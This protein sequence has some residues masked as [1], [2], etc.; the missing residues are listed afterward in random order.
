MLNIACRRVRDRDRI[1]HRSRD[2]PRSTRPRAAQFT[3]V[4][5]H[6]IRSSMLSV[7]GGGRLDVFRDAQRPSGPLR[8]EDRQC[9]ARERED[10]LGVHAQ[11]ESRR[12]SDHRPHHG[13]DRSRHERGVASIKMPTDVDGGGPRRK[14]S[15]SAGAYPRD[16]DR[17]SA[18]PSGG[19][20]APTRDERVRTSTRS[21]IMACRTRLFAGAL[22]VG[23]AGI[24]AIG[25]A[26][27]VSGTAPLI[28][29]AVAAARQ[30]LA[31]E[32]LSDLSAP[33]APASV[34]RNWR[35]APEWRPPG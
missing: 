7:I 8:R 1:R 22:D 6:G 14:S 3:G 12:P 16:T 28:P 20:C 5:P 35:L 23:R 30:Q 4:G 21:R 19:R 13:N 25:V 15:T 26:W 10:A 2:A 27:L 32:Q 33:F 11:Q 9:N 24:R 34:S 29:S 17:I 18:R 31:G